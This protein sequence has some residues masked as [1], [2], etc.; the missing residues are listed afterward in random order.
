M[1]LLSFFLSP[2]P[3]GPQP[4]GRRLAVVFGVLVFLL[5]F[6]VAGLALFGTRAFWQEAAE[7][8]VLQMRV[9]IPSEKA[10]MPPLPPLTGPASGGKAPAL[11]SS[12]AAKVLAVQQALTRLPGVVR[13]EPS[14]EV[15][16]VP[17]QAPEALSALPEATCL[18]FTLTP[19][20]HSAKASDVQQQ[21]R[22]IAP[23]ITVEEVPQAKAGFAGHGLGL[24]RV[25]IAIGGLLLLCLILVAALV[26]KSP[27]QASYATLDTLR[28]MGAQNGY[29]ARIF[30]NQI[31]KSA[32]AGGLVG[33]VLAA[34]TLYILMKAL[35]GFGLELDSA[36]LHHLSGTVLAVPLGVTLI[37]LLVSRIT[38]LRH[39]R[40]LD[41]R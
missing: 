34:G 25:V 4:G 3:V 26:T 38:V 22:R 14:Q 19:G 37:A 35:K 12:T 1:R 33:M 10:W 41:E 2:L 28:L 18:T 16:K 6:V 21:L 23:D 31:L 11:T 9:T 15:A 5:T 8:S 29:I 30:Q 27:L 32:L 17:P 20:A 39:L 40:Q 36:A 7:T 24:R 13:V